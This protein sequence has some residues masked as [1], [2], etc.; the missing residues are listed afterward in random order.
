MKSIKNIIYLRTDI[1]DEALVAGGSVAHM[2]GVIEGLLYQ[3]YT[4][5][6]ASTVMVEQLKNRVNY[7]PQLALFQ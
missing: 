7:F 1:W 4:V 5:I 6:F 2:V 3:G